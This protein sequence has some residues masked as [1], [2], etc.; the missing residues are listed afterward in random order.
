[1]ET[2]T[3]KEFD[4]TKFAREQKYRLSAIFAKMTKEE[5]LNYLKRKSIE[6]GRIKPSA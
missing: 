1:M 4:A 5:I 3:R 6:R 2:N